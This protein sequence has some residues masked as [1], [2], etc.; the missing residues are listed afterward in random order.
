MQKGD[1]DTEFNTPQSS[2]LV[3]NYNLGIIRGY[4]YNQPLSLPL[5][6]N[7]DFNF[8]RMHAIFLNYPLPKPNNLLP[9]L[10]KEREIPQLEIY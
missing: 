1:P 4:C 8:A 5:D 3:S 10:S 2:L 9:Q 7:I 6:K